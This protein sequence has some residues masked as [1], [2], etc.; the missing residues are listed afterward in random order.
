MNV[1]LQNLNDRLEKSEIEKE[2]VDEEFIPT[3][4]SPLR[5]F[6]SVKSKKKDLNSTSVTKRREI[7]ANSENSSSNNSNS[8]SPSGLESRN[9]SRKKKSNNTSL[10]EC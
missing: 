4:Q 3:E 10:W 5:R 2:P 8:T 7:R 9:K 1:F 6:N